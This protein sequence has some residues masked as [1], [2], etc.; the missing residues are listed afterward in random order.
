MTFAPITIQTADGPLT[1]PEGSTVADA[2]TRLIDDDTR[3]AQVATAVNGEFVARGERP[4]H[5]LR[6]GDT[7]LCFGAI[8]GG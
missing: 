7:L 1:L 3:R 8:T 2:L 6:D 4:W 5:V